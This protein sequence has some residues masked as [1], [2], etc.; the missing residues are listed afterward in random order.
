[1]RGLSR[2]SLLFCNTWLNNTGAQI[3]EIPLSF[4]TKSYLICKA[5]AFTI[6]V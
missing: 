2:I 6:Y 4:D 3:L 5:Q 1:M